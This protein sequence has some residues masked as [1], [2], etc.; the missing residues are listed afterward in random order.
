MSGFAQKM[1]GVVAAVGAA[2]AV[3]L[4]VNRGYGAGL[5]VGVV[6]LGALVVAC[7]AVLLRDTE[8]EVERLRG[9]AEDSRREAEGLRRDVEHGRNEAEDL[10]REV[11]GFRSDV[12]RL[13]SEVAEKERLKGEVERLNRLVAEKTGYISHLCNANRKILSIAKKGLG[14]E[15]L[16]QPE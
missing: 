4:T 10:R 8:R 6:A 2:C 12:E 14:H 13:T 1:C 15:P 5:A 16:Q 3:M 9:E 7:H 11:D